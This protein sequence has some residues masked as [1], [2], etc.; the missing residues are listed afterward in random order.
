MEKITE[1]ELVAGN[2]GQ[3]RQM[4]NDLIVEG[5]EPFGSAFASAAPGITTV[6]QAMV[7]KVWTPAE[8]RR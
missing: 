5:F 7:K 4:V 6:F 2:P 8:F 1:Y 3:I